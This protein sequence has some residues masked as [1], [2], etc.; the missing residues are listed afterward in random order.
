MQSENFDHA[1][2]NIYI[3][4]FRL[5]RMFSAAVF[6]RY[7]NS[8]RHVRKDITIFDEKSSNYTVKV[9][10]LFC[11]SEKSKQLVVVVVVLRGQG[12]Q[13]APGG[14][15]SW[16]FLVGVCRPVV[17]TRFQ[18]KKC[19]YPHPFSDQTSKIRTRFQTWSL[20]RNYVIITQIR[21][22]TQKLFKSRAMALVQSHLN[23]YYRYFSF[24]LTHLEL[25]R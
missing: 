20:G 4:V 25:T 17:Q 22:Q 15:Y 13:Q 21:A 24:S 19:H 7:V 23:S 2:R 6:L 9:K 11:V 18:T 12:W 1:R 16:E 8:A 10:M 3:Y 14:E 5:L